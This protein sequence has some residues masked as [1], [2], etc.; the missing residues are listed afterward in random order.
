MAKAIFHADF[1]Y[2]SRSRNAGWSVKANPHPQSF[3]KELIDAAIAA[4]VA[5]IEV[6]GKGAAKAKPADND[7]N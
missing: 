4:G 7:P 2:S 3:P 6:S 5:E 1:N